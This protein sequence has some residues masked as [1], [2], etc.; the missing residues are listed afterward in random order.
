ML[1]DV[2]LAGDAFL[3]ESVQLLCCFLACL[4]A[5]VQDVVAVVLLAL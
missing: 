2:L 4:Q 3:E 1:G 5:L